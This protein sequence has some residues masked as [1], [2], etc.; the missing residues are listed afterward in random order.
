MIKFSAMLIKIVTITGVSY[1]AGTRVTVAHGLGYT[2]NL[3]AILIQ[4]RSS[5]A[6]SD[7]TCMFSLVKV[8][9]TNVY[10]KP[11]RTIDLSSGSPTVG[12]IYIF[13]DKD[14]GQRREASA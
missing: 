6:D 11:L 9:A 10:I 8:D 12:K 14:I 3:D 5:D 1:T 13:A 4:E 7:N 2:P